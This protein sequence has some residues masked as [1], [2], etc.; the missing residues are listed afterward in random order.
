VATYSQ[1]LERPLYPIVD[2]HG[3]LYVGNANSP[4]VVE[5]LAGTTNAYRVLQVPGDEADGLAFDQQGNLY[6]A[7]RASD[8]VGG[9]SIEEFAPGS[10]QGH[11]LGMSLTAPQDLIVDTSG[12][13]VVAETETAD[14]ID[15]FPPGAQTPSFET[16][17]PNGSIPTGFAV[18]SAEA[19]FYASSI[20][21]DAFI[22]TYPLGKQGFLIQD[23]TPYIIQGITLTDAQAF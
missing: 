23:A 22:S 7:Y 12:N 3:N 4:T 11:V 9:G 18:D 14:R 19:N 10:A 17:L 13:I 15:V 2:S 21:G 16:T 6:V 8:G 1:D 20:G 5:Y